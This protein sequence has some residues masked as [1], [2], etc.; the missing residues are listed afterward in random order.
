MSDLR[1][2]PRFDSLGR[3][4]PNPVKNKIQ[5]NVFNVGVNAFITSEVFTH[6]HRVLQ[7]KHHKSE[8]KCLNELNC[9]LIDNNLK[10]CL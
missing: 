2:T 3:S 10:I 4:L 9:T 5:M 1:C 8:T 6:F 7:V